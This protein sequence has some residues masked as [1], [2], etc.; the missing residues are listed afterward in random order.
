MRLYR[1]DLGRFVSVDPLA[2]SYPWYTPYQFAGN[3]P[4]WAIDLDGLEP[5]SV[6][7]VKSSSYYYKSEGGSRFVPPKTTKITVTTYRF[8][9]PAAHLL[10]LVSG[11]GMADILET[12]IV[13][14]MGSG[15]P[16]YNSSDGRGGGMTLPVDDGT[17]TLAEI[18]LTNNFFVGKIDSKSTMRSLDINSHEVGH[19]KHIRQ[20]PRRLKYAATFLGRYIKS[21]GHDGVP[22]EKEAEVGRTTFREFR[23]F[24]RNFMPK[25]PSLDEI[26]ESNKSDNGKIKE[27]DYLWKHYKR[28]VKHGKP[29]DYT[30]EKYGA[31]SDKPKSKP[32][33]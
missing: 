23:D 16:A 6:V 29:N 15:L 28:W 18:R 19:I 9:K 22:Q 32:K 20:I 31:N 21:L 7:T 4:V 25:S 10:S 30:P 33:S 17:A 13:N 26:L 11:T 5:T 8:T 14:A 24:N 3:M 27:I 12:N 2:D 1:P